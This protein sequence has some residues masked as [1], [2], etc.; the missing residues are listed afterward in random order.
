MNR[1]ARRVLAALTSASFALIV[2][3]AAAAPAHADRCQPEELVG[4][5]GVVPEP[6]NPVCLVADEIVYPLLGC[7]QPTTL[8]GCQT[9]IAQI[10]TNAPNVPSY[11]LNAAFKAPG[12]VVNFVTFA[13][14]VARVCVTYDFTGR[15]ACVS[16][17][18]VETG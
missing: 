15:Q 8:M 7:P 1:T 9:S 14:T 12:T 17:S 11:A 2:P 5:A 6:A 3:I 16:T 18:G 13:G 4:V 10:R